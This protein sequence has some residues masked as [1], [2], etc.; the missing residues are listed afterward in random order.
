MNFPTMLRA[1]GFFFYFVG[2]L[3]AYLDIVCVVQYISKDDQWSSHDAPVF[4]S[5]GE[6]VPED[7]QWLKTSELQRLKI[8]ILSLQSINILYWK[9]MLPKHVYLGSFFSCKNFV[10]HGDSGCTLIFSVIFLK[11]IFYQQKLIFWSVV[12]HFSLKILAE[13]GYFMIR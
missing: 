13:G 3:C 10:W 11:M 8:E 12:N 6:T 2:M 5:V 1:W 9:C 7:K 4:W